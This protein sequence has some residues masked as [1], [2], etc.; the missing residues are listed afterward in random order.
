MSVSAVAAIPLRWVGPIQLTGP[1]ISDTISVPLATFETPLWYSVSRGAR[2]SRVVGGMSTVVIDS[3]MTR[4][5][6]LE[7]PNSVIA[8]RSLREID[9]LTPKFELAITS[10]SR[11]CKLLKIHQEQIG[12]LVFLRVEVSTGDAAGH[13]M[14]TKAA[15]AV[16]GVILENIPQLSYRSLSANYCTDKKVSAVNSLLGRGH[17]V[18]AEMTV[19]Q[20]VCLDVLDV[21]P[22]A[23][24]EINLKKNLI[25]SVAAGSL[26][27]A[28]AHFANMLLAFYLA[29]GQDG[30]N[31]VE[32]SQGMVNAD[33]CEDGGLRFSCTLTNIIVGCVGNG[34]EL[35]FVRKNLDK[36]GCNPQEVPGVAARRLASLAA[37]TVLCGELSLL[38]A[39]CKPDTLMR[40]HVAIERRKLQ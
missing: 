26:R 13:N 9:E 19:P 40:A 20:E 3:R 31:I 1:E 4:S 32:G 27:S 29:T 33:I 11:F 10:G 21:S 22:A 5:L 14:A 12:S 35:P 15:E 2:V 36:L 38:A 23:L 30:A 37:A 7:A 25:G 16:L 6:L 28:N 17:R 24:C 18:I 8:T 39:L 34:K